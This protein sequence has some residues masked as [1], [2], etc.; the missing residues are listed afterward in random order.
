MK[1]LFL[2]I[3]MAVLCHA[4]IAQKYVP[5]IGNNTVINYNVE[6]TA[7]GQKVQLTLTVTSITDPVTMA[8]SIPGLGTGTYQMSAAGFASGT[9]MKIKEPAEGITKL[10]D[11]ETLLVLSKSEFADLIKTQ[12]F[13]LNNGKFTV[14]TDATPAPYMINDK[15]ADVIHVVSANGKVDI[16][17]L[18]NP[19]FPLICRL[20]GFGGFDFDLASIKE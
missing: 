13:G 12:S 14:K 20:T 18:N 1:K 19:D 16:W 7:V 15:E 6:A 11:D 9:K 3:L 8:W 10:K 2:I 5:K 17:V 4:A